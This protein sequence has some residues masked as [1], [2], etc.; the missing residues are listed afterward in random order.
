MN[1][2]STSKFSLKKQVQL[3]RLELCHSEINIQKTNIA[4]CL[5]C[6]IKF[7]KEPSAFTGNIKIQIKT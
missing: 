5:K 3:R 1:N 6:N 7:S 4:F 2:E